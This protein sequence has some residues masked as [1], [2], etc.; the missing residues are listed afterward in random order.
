ME[1][2]KKER[3]RKKKEVRSNRYALKGVSLSGAPL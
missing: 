1:E 2:K 3:R